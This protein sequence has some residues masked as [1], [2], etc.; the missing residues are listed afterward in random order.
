MAQKGWF[1]MKR[2]I[3]FLTDVMSFGGVEKVLVNT[4]N[5][6]DCSVFEVTLLVMYKTNQEIHNISNIP[7]NIKVK[8]MFE[9]QVN[10][11]LKRLM[12]LFFLIIPR[13]MNFLFI[14]GSYDVIVTTKDMFT[15]PV[16]FKKCSKVMW[17]H[18]GLEHFD[19]EKASFYRRLKNW[20]QFRCYKR[21][22]KIILLTNIAKNRFVQKFG[23]EEKCY[24]LNNPLN[25][26]EIQRLAN[27]EVIDCQ[28]SDFTVVCSCRLSIEKGVE[29]LLNASRRLIRENYN[30]NVLIIGDGDQKAELQRLVFLDSKLSDK[31]DFIGF[32]ENPYKYIKKCTI[33]VSPSKTE[34]FSLSIAEAIILGLPVMST[35]CNGPIEILANGEFGYIVK[36]SEDGIYE[37]L[38]ELLTKPELIEYYKLKSI[39]RKKYFN[40]ETNINNLEKIINT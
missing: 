17:I 12:F 28:F 40:F 27:E 39:E 21:F 18:G 29:R 16:S 36:N 23:L 24:V 11:K 9:G 13:L 8:Y 37:G 20:L 34:G 2:K 10:Y 38:K 1:D 30:F 19:T 25:D 26:L 4:L 35:D 31:V 3:L 14:R 22:E 7:T 5:G 32:K 15:Y 6:I 33:Y